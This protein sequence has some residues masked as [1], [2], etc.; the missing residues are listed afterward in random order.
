MKLSSFS[1]SQKS[2][3]SQSQLQHKKSDKEEPVATEPEEKKAK[4]RDLNQPQGKL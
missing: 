4:Q 3:D 1:N 2:C